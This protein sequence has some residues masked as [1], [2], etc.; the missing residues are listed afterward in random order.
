MPPLHTIR[1]FSSSVTFTGKARPGL[2][3]E[4]ILSFS[5]GASRPSTRTPESQFG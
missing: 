1:R 5:P 2:A 3:S 4:W